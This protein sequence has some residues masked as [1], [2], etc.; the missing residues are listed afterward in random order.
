MPST[1]LVANRGEIAV[2]IFRT[3]KAMG[4]RTVAVYSDA[5]AS[6]LHVAAA[7]ASVRIGEAPAAE[8]YLRRDRI[9]DAA[10]ASG[11]ELIHPG[12]GFLAEDDRFADDCAAAGFTFVGPPASVL[13]AVGD[14]ASAREL[15]SR[16][17]VPILDGYQGAEMVFRDPGKFNGQ[18]FF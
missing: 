8:S 7:D 11:A 6:A 12:Y 10:R 4:M 3:A 9:I 15:A 13:R 17:G 1:L 18:V 14:K 5:D 16:S 2:R